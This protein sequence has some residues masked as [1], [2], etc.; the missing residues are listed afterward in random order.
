ML[1]YG[2]ISYNKLK[3]K[4]SQKWA[5]LVQYYIFKFIIREKLEE[6]ELLEGK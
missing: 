5:L 4:L 1:L 2:I 3:V 6:I